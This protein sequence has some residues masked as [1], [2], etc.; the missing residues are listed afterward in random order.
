MTVVRVM[1]ATLW[2]ADRA[3][4]MEELRADVVARMQDRGRPVGAVELSVVDAEPLRDGHRLRVTVTAV[5]TP[6][7]HAGA[8]PPGP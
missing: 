4:V 6:D 5:L 1:D 7:V 2:Y 3:V 8:E